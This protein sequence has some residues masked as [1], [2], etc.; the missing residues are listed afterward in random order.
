M[1]S[2]SDFGHVPVPNIHGLVALASKDILGTFK[3]LNIDASP[4]YWLRIHV[5]WYVHPEHSNN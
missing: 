4:T 1:R 2:T 3:Y 5:S